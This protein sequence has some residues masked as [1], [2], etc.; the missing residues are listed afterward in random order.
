MSTVDR[1]SEKPEFFKKRPTHWVFGVLGF[2]GFLDFLFERA[3][4]K[5]IG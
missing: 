2:T 3:V 1:G 5:L 4:A